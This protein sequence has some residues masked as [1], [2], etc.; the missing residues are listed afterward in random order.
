[1]SEQNTADNPAKTEIVEKN[2]TSDD[3]SALTADQLNEL[4][5]LNLA[6]LPAV[7]EQTTELRIAGAAYRLTIRQLD[8]LNLYVNCEGNIA[9]AVRMYS[10][11]FK[12][13]LSPQTAS[14]WLKTESARTYLLQCLEDR[15]YDRTITK[16]RWVNET[17]MYRDGEKR[18]DKTGCFMHKLLGMAK[19]F[20]ASGS[21]GNRTTI[22]RQQIN[23]VQANG[24]EV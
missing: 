15:G 12:T 13:R 20:I 22:E 1:M 5:N 17:L 21:G 2:T 19:G 18:L 16:E 6:E 11:A 23:F 4:N 14:K 7:A 24:Q 9:E 3:F 10:E 8:F